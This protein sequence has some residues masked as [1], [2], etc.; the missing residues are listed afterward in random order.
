[1]STAWLAS[2]AHRVTDSSQ[3]GR[4]GAD[5]VLTRLAELM[6]I[7]LLRRYLEDLPGG[8]QGWLAGLRD[9]VV[10]KVIARRRCNT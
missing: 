4:P 5:G 2:F 10:G 9:D 7:E 6:F 8:Q 3:L 1:M